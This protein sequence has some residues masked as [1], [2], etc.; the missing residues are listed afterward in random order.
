MIMS[1]MSLEERYADQDKRW[2]PPLTFLRDEKHRELIHRLRDDA[3]EWVA[4][5]GLDQFTA[6]PHSKSEFAHDDIDRL[7]DAGQFVGRVYEGR[8]V[9]VVAITEPDPDLW[10]RDEMTE[11]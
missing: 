5:K 9:A 8:V 1:A 6:G 11:P 3:E 10:T 4:S 7:F 2:F